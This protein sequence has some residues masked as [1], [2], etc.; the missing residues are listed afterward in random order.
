[1]KLAQFLAEDLKRAI[2]I[3]VEEAFGTA[4]CP[5]LPKLP[6]AAGQTVEALLP[7]K[8]DGDQAPLSTFSCRAA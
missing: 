6:D 8:L 7:P 5:R 1:M 2:A 3:Y 4:P